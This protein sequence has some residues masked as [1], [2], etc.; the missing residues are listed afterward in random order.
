MRCVIVPYNWRINT[1]VIGIILD[2]VVW[3]NHIMAFTM[4]QRELIVEAQGMCLASHAD[5]LLAHH[6]ILP[7]KRVRNA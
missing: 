6:A 2:T 5:V 7:R 4:H 1:D 3:I